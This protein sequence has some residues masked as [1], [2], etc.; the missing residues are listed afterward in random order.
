MTQRAMY[1]ADFIREPGSYDAGFHR[2]NALIEA[3]ARSRTS[4]RMRG[5]RL[6]RG[7]A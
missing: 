6:E 5:R 2:L 4:R 3:V 7:V 1:R